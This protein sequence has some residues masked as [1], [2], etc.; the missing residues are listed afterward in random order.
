MPVLTREVVVFRPAFNLVLGPIGP[1]VVVRVIPMQEALILPFQLAIEDGAG[2]ARVL[3]AQPVGFTEIRAID[4]GVV[5][6]F[7]F[8]VGPAVKRLSVVRVSVLAMV[9][10]Q[11]VATIGQRDGVVAAVQ[12]HAVDEALAMQM[13]QV[14]ASGVG[15]RIAGRKEVAFWDETERA[16]GRQGP[17]F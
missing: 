8:L 5:G 14:L 15:R 10:E 2:D 3:F 12:G 16:D 11:L 9:L 7:A 6:P 1:A 17:G 13:T 4:R